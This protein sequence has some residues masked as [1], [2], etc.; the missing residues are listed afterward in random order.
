MQL[1]AEASI[2][3]AY[4]VSCCVF[5]LLTTI[6]FPLL[7]LFASPSHMGGSLL[8]SCDSVTSL[9]SALCVGTRGRSV[10]ADDVHRLWGVYFAVLSASALLVGVLGV[11]ATH[12]TALWCVIAIK[13]TLGICSGVVD[14]IGRA[15]VLLLPSPITVLVCVEYLE[16]AMYVVGPLLGGLLAHTHEG[17]L[18]A[19]FSVMTAVFLCPLLPLLLPRTDIKKGGNSTAAGG[20]CGPQADGS[21]I[22]SWRG[23]LSIMPW[24]S[25]SMLTLAMALPP[26][27]G[28]IVGSDHTHHH[29]T[30]LDR[31]IA[32][33]LPPLSNALCAVA[34]A[35]TMMDDGREGG[36]P[37]MA[38][39]GMGVGASLLMV[40]CWP[41]SMTVGFTCAGGCLALVL[42]P[43][44]PCIQQQLARMKRG[45]GGADGSRMDYA[46]L[47]SSVSVV[48]E[49]TGEGF[50]AVGCAWA[51]DKVGIEAVLG[52][53]GVVFGGLSVGVMAYVYPSLC[54]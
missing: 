49:L 53:L 11:A 9:L 34:L 7:P 39:G 17:D 47:A 46:L 22:V 32:L 6:I 28:V 18:G 41:G 4:L 15:V 44:L 43:A 2:A 45:C 3:G 16:A 8:V 5:Q 51:V 48:C 1:S 24:C 25:V 36:R 19:A 31:G 42:V 50:V 14:V 12:S 26:L 54:G 33:A 37:A 40:C 52:G 38:C 20:G 27:F 23:L 10:A 30:Y 29:S 35:C 21:S 13:A